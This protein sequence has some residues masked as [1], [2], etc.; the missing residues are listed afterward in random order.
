MRHVMRHVTF[1]IVLNSL[2]SLTSTA[3]S[4]LTLKV[5]ELLDRSR[6]LKMTYAW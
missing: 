1:M 5:T 6:K 3:N 4:R 2:Q